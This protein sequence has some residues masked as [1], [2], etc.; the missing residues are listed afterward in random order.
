MTVVFTIIALFS[1]VNDTVCHESVHAKKYL[2][3]AKA[4]GHVARERALT[5]TVRGLIVTESTVRG[6]I[7]TSLSVEI[8]KITK[9]R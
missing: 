1:V 3:V 7:V 9:E 2:S 6:A 4:K 8:A 5:T